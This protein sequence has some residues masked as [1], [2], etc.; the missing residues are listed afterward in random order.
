MNSGSSSP[1]FVVNGEGV[2]GKV[3]IATTTADAMLSVGPGQSATTTID[4]GKVCFRSV[5]AS[6]ETI[7]W[8]FQSWTENDGD[9]GEASINIATSTTSCF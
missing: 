1:A 2:Y 3:G 9:G 7:Y 4:V 6:N 5:S 8:W